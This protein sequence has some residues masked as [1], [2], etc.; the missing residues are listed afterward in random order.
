M[1]Q[2]QDAQVSIDDML[3]WV[4]GK[5]CSDQ[6]VGYAV[7]RVAQVGTLDQLV[8]FTVALHAAIRQTGTGGPDQAL[9]ILLTP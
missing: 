6:A 3:A 7:R 1:T 9:Y 5:R 8:A 4:R 2:Q